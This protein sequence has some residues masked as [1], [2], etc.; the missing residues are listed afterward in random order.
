M[1]EKPIIFNAQMVRAILDGSKTQTRRVVKIA[2]G[3][4]IP[5]CPYGQV[6]DKLWVRETWARDDDD[7]VL[8]Y[9]ADIGHDINAAAWEQGRIEGNARHHWRP[10]I[11]IPRWASRINLEIVG[12]GLERL[13]D[14]TDED[15]LS[16]GVCPT[17]TGCYPGVPRAAFAE[18]WASIYGQ[19]S[20]AQNPLVW[21]VEFTRVTA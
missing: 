6:G 5:R 10:S 18:L 16:E 17:K 15:A 11:Y 20:W 1:S 2:G 19:T 7:G 13:H 9:R 8:M 12:I 21:R 4:I 14:I 3:Q